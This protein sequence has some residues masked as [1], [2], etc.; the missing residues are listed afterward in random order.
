MGKLAVNGGAPVRTAPF[1]SWPVWD[2]REEEA[3]L[4]AVRSGVWGGLPD[5]KV[6]EFGSAFAKAQDARYGIGVNC[7][8]HALQ[9]A[10]RALDVKWGDEVIV[11]AIT[12]IATP[13][14]ALY[15]GAVAIYCDVDPETF[16]MDPQK[17]E[18]LITPRTRAIIP[19]HW[20]GLP[21]DLD[22][23]LEIGRKHGIPVVEDAAHAHGAKWRGK[24]CG[25]W[26]AL[27]GFSFQQS[28]T[29]TAGEGGCILTSDKRLA[30]ICTSLINCGRVESGDEY[31]TESPFGYNFRLTTLHAA[32]LLAQLTRL[33]ELSEKRQASARFLDAELAKIEGIRPL[34]RDPRVTRQGYYIYHLRYDAAGFGGLPRAQLTKALRAEGIPVGGGGSLVYRSPLMAQAAQAC[35]ALSV[36]AAGAPIDYSKVSCPEAERIEAEV[37]LRMQQSLLLAEQ[38]DLEDVVRAFRKVREHARELVPA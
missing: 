15:I 29:I 7:G 2:K 34:R 20:G 37:A 28:K 36:H 3:V 21:A 9:V 14:A 32:L 13:Q 6:R 31:L 33:E 17:I 23:I 38:S 25:S 1:P 26:G 12:W 16:N 10:L 30:E 22:A 5:T 27:G 19:V 35:C 4:G 24:G 18:A 8:T 11:P